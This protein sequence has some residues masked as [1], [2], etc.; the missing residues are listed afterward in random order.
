MTRQ[1]NPPA[2]RIGLDGDTLGRKRTG[3]E[4]YLASLM[5]GL[6]CVDD[7]NDYVV[8]VRDPSKVGPS[9]EGLTRFAFRRV[10]PQSIWLRFPIGLPLAL[11]RDPVDLLHVQYFVPP[12][13]PCPVVVTV[14]DISFAVRPD[15][16]TRKDRFLLKTL[17]PWSLRRAARII[18]DVEYTKRD[19]VGM[20]DLSPEDIEVIPLAADPR[21]R[22]MDRARCRQIVAER[23]GISGPFVLYVGTL[24]P[25][26][27]VATLIRAYGMFRERTGL[28]HKLV[29]TGKPKYMYQSVLDALNEARYP[30]DIVLTGFVADAD[31]P[32]YYNAASVFAFPSLY[33]GFGLPL[34]EAMACG[35]PVIS[36][37]VTS[38]PE[39]A[40]DA[41][42]LV[43]PTK[44]EAFCD[45]LVQVLGDGEVADRLSQR[46]LEQAAR[47]TW[48]RTARET[49]AV[50][51]D[52][53]NRTE[54]AERA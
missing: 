43:D 5:R 39:V 7:T 51:R 20:Y 23:H 50:Y 18:T 1:P 28:P 15:F 26:K 45:A 38:L 46:G 53:L 17:V 4:S 2:L 16:F 31:L 49:L 10:A 29:L 47:F 12:A 22:P 36:S 54:C 21:Y 48:E 24:Q 25:R 3:D 40:G 41:A 32:I 52:V 27:N 42:L 6:G 13:A 44:P 9:F 11:R 30:D 37:N 35:T 34:L 14:H 19:L 8:Y 33:E